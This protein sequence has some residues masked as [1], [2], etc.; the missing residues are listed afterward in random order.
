MSLAEKRL[1]TCIWNGLFIQSGGNL[2]PLFFKCRDEQCWRIPVSSQMGEESKSVLA[3]SLGEKVHMF[4]SPFK[5]ML[6]G[7]G[8]QSSLTR[9][10]YHLKTVTVFG[11]I[12]CCF[13]ILMFY[14]QRSFFV[15]VFFLT[16]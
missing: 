8:A 11:K 15:V 16:S 14:R 10:K 2:L 5:E 9:K 7:D 3:S 12:D 6:S 13:L 4:N 1:H